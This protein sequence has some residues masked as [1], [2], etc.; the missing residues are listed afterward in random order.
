MPPPHVLV[1]PVDVKDL[2]SADAFEPQLC[3]V[4]SQ[5][6]TVALHEQPHLVSPETAPD[7]E[8]EQLFWASESLKGLESLKCIGVHKC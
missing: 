1:P 5:V 8:H 2:P 3:R 4:Q 7:L 6:K